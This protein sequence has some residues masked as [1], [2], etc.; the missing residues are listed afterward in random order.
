MNNRLKCER[1]SI[2][3]PIMLSIL[4]PIINKKLVEINVGA[5]TKPQVYQN[6]VYS[7]RVV[8][9]RVGT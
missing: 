3:L 4:P 1:L 6:A 7:Q 9:I 5:S 8:K 2:L